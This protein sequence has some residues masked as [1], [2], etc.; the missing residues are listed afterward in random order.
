M[1]GTLRVGGKLFRWKKTKLSSEWEIIMQDSEIET[2]YKS[3]LPVS[4]YAGLR[5][6]YDSGY[7][8]GGALNTATI[9][10]V[11]LTQSAPLANPTVTTV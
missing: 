6:V 5:A 8:A 4:H 7:A 2:I 11:S 3:A 10:D 1:T 9:S